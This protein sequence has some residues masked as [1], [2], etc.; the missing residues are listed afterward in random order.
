MVIGLSGV[1]FIMVIELSG[2]QFGLKSYTWFQNRT[3]AQ[4]GGDLKSQ[5]KILR[6]EVQLLFDKI[7]LKSHNLIAKFAKRWLISLSFSCNVI[8]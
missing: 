1:Q 8:G 4:R 2:V 6:L 5:T 3:S 7:R